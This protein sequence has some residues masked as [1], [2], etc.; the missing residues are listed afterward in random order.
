MPAIYPARLKTQAAEL[1]EQ[2]ANPDVFLR[3]L[4][5]L[6][7]YYSNR[8]YRPGQSGEPPPLI[9]QY[10]V[11]PPV[12]RQVI[13]ELIPLVILNQEAGLA[14]SD[15]LW[16]EPFLEFRQL[17]AKLLGQLKPDPPGAI[18]ERVNAWGISGCGDQLQ[19]IL[20]VEGLARLRQEMPHAYLQQVETW[21]SGE[22]LA[23]QQVG[24][25]AVLAVLDQ[26][27]FGNLPAIYRILTPQIRSAQSKLRSDIL[28]VVSLLAKRSPRET[29]AFLKQNLVHKTEFPAIPWLVRHSLQFFPPEIRESLRSSLRAEK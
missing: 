7:D 12:L 5:N 13:K 27:Q 16:G 4:H 25:Q 1:A 2:F 3:S 21:I 24:L 9:A 19:K 23:T 11:P 17:A 22:N 10:N 6:L 15:A 14:L 8:T 29:A 20:V 18:I 26:D 28:A